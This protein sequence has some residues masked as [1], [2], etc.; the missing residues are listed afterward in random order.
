MSF[1]FKRLA[2]PDVILIA[3]T[4]F[5]DERGF[6]VETYK[7]SVFEEQGIAGDFCQDNHSFSSKGV[8]RGLHYQ[9]N[10]AA[11]GKLIR[12]VTGRVFDVAVDIR[13]QSPTY[14]QFVCV[15]L[16]SYNKHILWMPPGFA[17]AA[18][19]LDDDTHLFYRVTG[20]EY[21]PQYERSICWND[22]ALDIPW[23]IDQS[24]LILS[25]KDKAAPLL[26]DADNNF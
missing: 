15:E 25:D 2:I 4:V 23:P 22:P 18:L 8:L 14:G 1:T 13:R 20:S 19:V 7:K 26:S 3:P 5:G 6:F 17:H 21:N 11:Q 9:L 16:S 12:V 24:A 10:P